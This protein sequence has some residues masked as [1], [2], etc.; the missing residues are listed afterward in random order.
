[1]VLTVASD[2]AVATTKRAV[3]AGPCR[4]GGRARAG[5]TTS[6]SRTGGAGGETYRAESDEHRDARAAFYRILVKYTI[7]SDKN[8]L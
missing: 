3:A 4:R 5:P 2:A 1:M 7:T 6:P 8:L